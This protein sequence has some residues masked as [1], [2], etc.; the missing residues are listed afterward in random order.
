MP[1]LLKIITELGVGITQVSEAYKMGSL[2]LGMWSLLCGAD[3]VNTG[4]T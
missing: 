1:H 4:S 2:Q 3:D